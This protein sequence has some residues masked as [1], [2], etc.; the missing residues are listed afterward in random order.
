MLLP[1]FFSKSAAFLCSLYT[2]STQYTRILG[3]GVFA[4]EDDR[5]IL[6][7]GVKPRRDQNHEEDRKKPAA[8]AR[9]RL[10]CHG[11]L[12]WFLTESGVRCLMDD[13]HNPA[14]RQDPGPWFS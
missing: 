7:A 11:F 3:S 5:M 2:V 1:V 14:R 9:G 4:E 8:E 10:S 6:K 13:M 12:R